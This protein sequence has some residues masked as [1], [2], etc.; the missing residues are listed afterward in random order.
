[1]AA[2]QPDPSVPIV[3]GAQAAELF[4]PRMV[5]LEQEH[6]L[7][8]LLDA[9]HRPASPGRAKK[10]LAARSAA[11]FDVHAGVAIETIR[12]KEDSAYAARFLRRCLGG[13]SPRT[14]AT[15]SSRDA[16]AAGLWPV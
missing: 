13:A 7:V 14:F 10:P 2:A 9:K 1:M 16:L 6:V 12:Q 3:T 4:R 8:L 5:D 11:G 15:T